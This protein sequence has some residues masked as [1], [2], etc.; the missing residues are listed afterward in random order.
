[1][2]GLLSGKVEADETYIGGKPRF[3]SADN[4][5]WHAK[6][7]AV[8]AL[9]ERGGRVRTGVLAEVTGKNLKDAI[10]E[11]VDRSAT[12]YTDE[13]MGY[14]RIGREFAGGH[15]TTKHS[16]HEYARGD[17]HSNTV[18]GFFSIVKRGLN[19]IYHAVSK[20]HLH[21]YLCEFEFRYNH[22]HLDDGERTTAVIRASEGKRLT[23]E[24]SPKTQAAYGAEA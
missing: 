18:E 17:V 8:M 6:K 13:H 21:R 2:P 10:R 9:V 1:M 22:R 19:G 7:P 20:E 5:K 3:R 14:R 11:N 23:Y 16:A 24:D 12:I 15:H 4:A